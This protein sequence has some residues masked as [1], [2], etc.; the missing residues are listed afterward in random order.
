MHA[1]NEDMVALQNAM[2]EKNGTMLHYLSNFVS[3]V[4]VACVY[5]WDLTLVVIALIPLLAAVTAAFAVLAGRLNR[6][7]NKAYAECN[8]VATEAFAAVRT[9]YSFNGEGR[10]VQRYQGLLKQPL[11]AGIVAGFYQGIALGFC[12]LL[13]W[14]ALRWHCGMAACVSGIMHIKGAM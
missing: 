6:Q 12:G 10:I 8:G 14:A 7:A 2:G 13:C 5:A 9:V 1:L 4:A 11:R 3:G